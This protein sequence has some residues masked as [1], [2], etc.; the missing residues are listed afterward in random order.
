M[1]IIDKEEIIR[2]TEEYGDIWILLMYE[3]TGDRR[4]RLYRLP[5]GA[6]ARAGRS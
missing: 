2:L 3:S 1:I 4:G 5:P 6:N